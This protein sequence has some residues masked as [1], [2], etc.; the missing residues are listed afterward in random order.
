MSKKRNIAFIDAQNLY[1]GTM[2]DGWTVDFKKFRRYLQD[3]YNVDEAYYFVGY[4]IPECNYLYDALQKAG[5][6]IHFK[7]YTSLH[8]SGKKGN[9]DVFMAFSIM[10]KLLK[11]S[12]DFDKIVIV[13]G[14]GDFYEI[15]NF[16][17][18]EGR[19]E[20][21]L[22]PTKEN[23]SSLYKKLGSEYYDF[24][25]NPAIKSRIGRQKEKGS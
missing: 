11:E 24:L 5:F 2:S 18:E 8:E 16:L 20:K 6:I 19:L 15:A 10:K 21:I 3:K 12:D 4:V 25:E 9:V 17:I 23:A 7:K 22:H 13:T 14:D 1:L